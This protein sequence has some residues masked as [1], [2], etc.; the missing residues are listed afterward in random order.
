M[1]VDSDEVID[2]EKMTT[3]MENLAINKPA[4]L[5]TKCAHW[6]ETYILEEAILE[7]NEEKLEAI[8][9]Q[10]DNAESECK[11]E[12]IEQVIAEREAQLEI[13]DTQF[14]IGTASFNL[15]GPYTTKNANFLDAPREMIKTPAFI[16][17]WCSGLSKGDLPKVCIDKKYKFEGCKARQSHLFMPQALY[18]TIGSK[19]LVYPI[20]ICEASFMGSDVLTR[21]LSKG[22]SICQAN[23]IRR[24]VLG[25]SKADTNSFIEPFVFDNAPASV[26]STDSSRSV[27]SVSSNNSDGRSD[28]NDDGHK[29]D[30]VK[31]PNEGDPD[32]PPENKNNSAPMTVPSPTP[33]MASSLPFFLKLYI[34]HPQWAESKLEP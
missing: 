22:C 18:L 1:L 31:G 23:H 3:H 4:L 14:R 32:M 10:D 16:T 27:Q 9:G 15:K 30:Q 8:D 33:T 28:K 26:N 21:L 17:N 19:K 6:I 5:L 20:P 34:L 11:R 24:T 7:A 13:L 29:R 2:K 25:L 12:K